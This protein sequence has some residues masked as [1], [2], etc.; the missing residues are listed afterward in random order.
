MLRTLCFMKIR[1]SE[2]T[3]IYTPFYSNNLEFHNNPITLYYSFIKHFLLLLPSS[4]FSINGKI[5]S[6]SKSPF[7]R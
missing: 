3:T 1:F 5:L 7:K 6:P 4:K 2:I